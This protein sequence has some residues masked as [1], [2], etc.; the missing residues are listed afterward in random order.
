MLY[1]QGNVNASDINEKITPTMIGEKPNWN[2]IIIE[3][4]NLIVD[5]DLNTNNYPL[6][7]VLVRKTQPLLTVGNIYIYNTVHYISAFMYADGSV[8]SVK[9]NSFVPSGYVKFSKS[10]SDRTKALQD[11]LVIY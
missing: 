7:I 5:E 2:T 10:D 3:D 1:I 4:G 6:A 11:Q 9:A 8:Q